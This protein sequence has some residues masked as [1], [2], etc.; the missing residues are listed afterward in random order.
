MKLCVAIATEDS[1]TQHLTTML[2]GGIRLSDKIDAEVVLLTSKKLSIKLPKRY[3]NIYFG[4]AKP[5]HRLTDFLFSKASLKYDV[6]FSCDDDSLNCTKGMHQYFESQITDKPKYW[7]GV[8]GHTHN[9][10]AA[11]YGPILYKCIVNDNKDNKKFKDYYCG[12]ESGALNKAAIVEMHKNKWSKRVLECFAESAR[13]PRGDPLWASELVMRS[14]ATILDME[15][16]SIGSYSTML[17][18]LLESSV[19]VKKS[20]IKIWHCHFTHGHYSLTH[21]SLNHALKKGPFTK[22]S[23]CVSALFPFLKLGVKYENFINKKLY[24]G[25]FFNPYINLGR[26]IPPPY[27]ISNSNYVIL[28]SNNKTSNGLDWKPVRNGLEIV[29]SNNL[30]ERYIWTH[31]NILVGIKMINNKIVSEMPCLFFE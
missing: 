9:H 13:E 14:T 7:G 28:Y 11:P 2:N 17:P 19:L 21:G 26:S 1:R 27:R 5:F 31:D 3:K 23:D 15:T 30:R 18:R 16:Q 25:Y 12:W 6:I 4:N 20:H 24:L 29:F 8:P 10:N 22:S